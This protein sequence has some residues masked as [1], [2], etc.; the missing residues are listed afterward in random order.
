[1]RNHKSFCHRLTE[2]LTLPRSCQHI[3]TVFFGPSQ[4]VKVDAFSQKFA[5]LESEYHL[6]YYLVE[7]RVCATVQQKIPKAAMTSVCKCLRSGSPGLMRCHAATLL[8]RPS[9]T[10]RVMASIGCATAVS[11]CRTAELDSHTN[12]KTLWF[13]WC[14]RGEATEIESFLAELAG[15]GPATEAGGASIDWHKPLKVRFV[16][17]PASV[18]VCG[19]RCTDTALRV[20]RCFASWALPDSRC[21]TSCSVRPD[22]H[23][24]HPS[25]SLILN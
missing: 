14:P 22:R 17:N 7:P 20:L 16:C 11:E 24:P 18:H 19:M 21:W 12:P 9:G 8:F 15:Q 2:L 10:S 6:Y 3:R 23:F 1:M 5:G 4:L 13:A 25:H